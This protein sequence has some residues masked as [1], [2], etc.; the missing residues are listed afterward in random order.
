MSKPEP[1][2]YGFWGYDLFPHIC[3]GAG[4]FNDFGNFYAND[5]EFIM[6]RKN[7][8]AVRT[9]EDGKKIKNAIDSIKKEYQLEIKNVENK[10]AAKVNALLPELKA[11]RNI[12]E[13]L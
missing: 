13:K 1:R 12:K 4:S 8:L 6:G 2:V 10:F 3:C 11:T 9:L 7:I 5:Y